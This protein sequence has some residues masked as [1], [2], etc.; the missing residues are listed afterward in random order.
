MSIAAGNIREWVGQDVVDEGGDKIG[1]LESIYV[2][3]ADDR[4]FF[5]TVTVGGVIGGHRLV[6]VP[7]TGAVVG[8]KYLKVQYP[9]KL[10]REAPSI[11][12][13]GELVAER[14]TEVFGHYGI[15][16]DTGAGGNRRLGRR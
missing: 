13:D 5:A 4:P 16:Y 1:S 10:V 9:K 12:T 15:S 3:T 11:E 7:L 14:E 8:P 2:D 6:F